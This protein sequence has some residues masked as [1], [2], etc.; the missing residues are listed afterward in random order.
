MIAVDFWRAMRAGKEIKNP[1]AW[2]NRQNATNALG[3]ILAFAAAVLRLFGVDVP[4]SEA[5]QLSIAAGGAT[6]LGL[7]NVVLT[8]ATTRKIGLPGL[9]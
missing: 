5:D 1:A 6:V 2:K 7:V 3:C 8:T 4:V 9:K